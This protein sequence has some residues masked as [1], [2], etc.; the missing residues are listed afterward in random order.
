[1]NY[2]SRE[3]VPLVL[4][5]HRDPVIRL[6]LDVALQNANFTG[7]VR[8]AH[9]GT[10]EYGRL[11]EHATVVV[12]DYDQGID[13]CGKTKPKAWGYTPRGPRV[14]VVS[15]RQG[16][17]EIRHAVTAGVMGYI[18]L[19]SEPEEYVD[20]I[21][22]LLKN[23]RYLTVSAVQKMADSM[24]HE[25]LTRRELEVL[26]CLVKG[27]VNK[28]ISEELDIALG[29][30]KAHVKSIF[31][32]FDVV[33]RTQ[34]VRVALQRGLSTLDLSDACELTSVAT[35]DRESEP[36]PCQIPIMPRSSPITTA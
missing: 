27:R 14:L 6:G 4:L 7:R 15:H 1:M 11:L 17:H 26:A 8:V 25:P 29:T 2:L 32:K 28:Q 31:T 18:S 19:G 22:A 34:A 10:A 35:T 16:E 21:K 33:T 23:T 9:T 30:V 5:S 36:K 20:A 12:A 13:I 3:S 24:M